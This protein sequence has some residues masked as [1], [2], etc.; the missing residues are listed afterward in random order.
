MPRRLHF[1][2]QFS[3]MEGQKVK[4]QELTE[5]LLTVL[6]VP[7]AESLLYLSIV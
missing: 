3:C 2:D 6:L 5:R 4:T 7:G 1:S